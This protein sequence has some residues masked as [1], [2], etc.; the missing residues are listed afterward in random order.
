[1][2]DLGNIYGT[3]IDG[4]NTLVIDFSNVD[5]CG[6][7]NVLGDTALNSNVYIT[8]NLDVIG[9]VLVPKIKTT[10]Y[11]AGDTY[12][13]GTRVKM[14]Q[15]DLYL[16]A[17]WVHIGIDLDGATSLNWD[18]PNNYANNSSRIIMTAK[19][20][21]VSSQSV[22]WSDD[23]VKHFE[24]DIVDSLNTI[25]KLKPIKYTKTLKIYPDNYNGPIDEEGQIESG[26]IAQEVLKI[27]DLSYCVIDEY[28]NDEGIVKI[29]YTLKYNDLF[30]YNIAATKELDII[31]QNQQTEI[32]ELKNENILLKNSL[33]ILLSEAGKPNI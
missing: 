28:I 22:P 18:Y 8:G 25:R 7:L 2:D 16:A 30:V 31:V 14:F 11:W 26:F 3:T 9:E 33:N 5:I 29:P 21:T 20:I 15:R 6:N 17:P 24:E 1:M 10:K 32:T 19:Q 23:R 13:D 4:S 27:P 12:L